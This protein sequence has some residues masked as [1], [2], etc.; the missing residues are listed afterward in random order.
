MTM[1]S[2]VMT[3]DAE[4]LA[5]KDSIRHAADLMDRLNVG[6]LPVCDGSRLV[7]IVTDRD[8]VVRAVAIGLEPATPV[9]DV[10]SGPVEYCFEDDDIDEAEYKFASSQ[11]RRL[12]VLDREKHLVGM[13]SIGDVATAQDGG[14]SSTLGAVSAPATPDRADGFHR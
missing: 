8:I 4:T 2:E 12:P 14:L 1:I 3:R 7:G 9:E 5:P 11:I 10:A 13:V 6:A